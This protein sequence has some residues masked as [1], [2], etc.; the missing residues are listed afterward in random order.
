[1]DLKVAVDSVD[2]A[3]LI[4]VPHR[5][6][7]SKKIYDEVILLYNSKK[8]KKKDCGRTGTAEE[9]KSPIEKT[10]HEFRMK[11]LI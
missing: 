11:N 4:N 10:G 1:M 2:S 9:M 3:E 6:K 5:I 7:I 8:N